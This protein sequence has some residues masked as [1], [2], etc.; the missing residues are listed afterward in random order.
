MKLSKTFRHFG[1]ITLMALVI[2]A[3]NFFFPDNPGFLNSVINPYLFFALFASVYYGLYKGLYSAV[4]MVFLVA[5]PFPFIRVAYWPEL[6]VTDY[7]RDLADKAMIPGI[8]TLLGIIIFGAVRDSSFSRIQKLKARLKTISREKGILKRETN[9]LKLVN[10]ELDGRVLTQ[11]DSI[12]ALYTRIHGLYSLSLEK[13]LDALVEA[14][15]RFAG[16]TSCSIWEYKKEYKYLILKAHTRSEDYVFRGMT[17]MADDCIEGWVVRNNILFSAKMLIKNEGIKKMDTGRNLFTVPILAGHNIWG[18][19]NIEELPFEKYNLY[20]EK[21]LLLI[22][23]LAG[24][25]LDRAIEYD[26]FAVHEAVHPVSGLPAFSQFFVI[27]ETEL[28]RVNIEKQTLSI[29]ILELT[30]YPE[31]AGELGK[32]LV[33]RFYTGLSESIKK[34]S[35]GHARVFHYKSDSQIC[36]LYPNLDYDG[37]SLFCLNLLEMINTAE[38]HVRAQIIIPEIILGYASLGESQ[39][40]ADELINVAENLLEMQKL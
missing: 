13:A 36:L 37:A 18:V 25:A 1:E 39:H 17:L 32:E 40:S 4:L 28:N 38:W 10:A 31:L 33:F 19:L 29:F 14:V 21:L 20:T 35:E 24:P 15:E 22:M 27:L 7:W 16:A 9:A 2:T 12:I 5:L 3:I 26:T 8:M 11:E 34:L 30:N 23:A 6:A